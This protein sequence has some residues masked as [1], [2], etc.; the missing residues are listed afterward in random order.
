MALF[1]VYRTIC[2]DGLASTVGHRAY[3]VKQAV[4]IDVYGITC[5]TV[6]QDI[7]AV[8]IAETATVSLI[9]KGRWANEEKDHL[10]EN[11]AN[12]RHDSERARVGGPC[13]QPRCGFGPGDKEPVWESA[14]L[15]AAHQ[16]C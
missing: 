1:R 13:G 12:H 4:Q 10:P 2:P 16:L 7:L 5:T 6:E 11:K 8:P 15:E 14:R 3:L 9:G